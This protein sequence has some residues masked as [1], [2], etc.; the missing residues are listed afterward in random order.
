MPY[1]ILGCWALPH[2]ILGECWALPHC[3][4]GECWALPQ[5]VWCMSVPTAYWGAGHCHTAYWVSAGH[6][7][8]QCGI[9]Q[10]LLHTGCWALP[11]PV[12]YCIPGAGHCHNQCPTAYWVLGTATTNVVYVSTTPSISTFW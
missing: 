10:Y 1:C 6:C 3:I 8:N 12:P 4:L 5:P 9:C 2:C 11:Q 7:H